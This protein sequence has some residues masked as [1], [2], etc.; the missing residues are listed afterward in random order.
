DHLDFDLVGGGERKHTGSYY[1]PT[2]LVQELVRSALQP[3][4]QDRLSAGTQDD[5]RRA[6]LSITICDPA[7]GSG[8]FL[9]AAARRLAGELA[10]LDAAEA[11]P[12][13]EQTRLALR[14][15]IRHCLFGVDV[16]PLAVDL[17]KL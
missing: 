17:C 4:I 3:L 5:K 7:C 16:N 2:T 12:T 6:L 9:L 11:E 8:H 1:T 10:R 13:P 15:V 14:E